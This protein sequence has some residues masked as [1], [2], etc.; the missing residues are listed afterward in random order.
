MANA[1]DRPRQSKRNTHRD[2]RSSQT[3]RNQSLL[4]EI[5]NPNLTILL[6]G[7]GRWEG[8]YLHIYEGYLFRVGLL[9]E[10][11]HAQAVQRWGNDSFSV[12][13]LVDTSDPSGRML[14]V[15]LLQF[16]SRQ[17]SMRVTVEGK[18]TDEV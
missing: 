3:G 11:Y 10:W 7:F 13:L 14:R 18:A 16:A 2:R 4:S 6:Q 15:T 9:V 8:D 12:S 1:R 5:I 17:F